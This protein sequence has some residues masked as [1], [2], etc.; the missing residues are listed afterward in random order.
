MFRFNNRKDASGNDGS[1]SDNQSSVNWSNFVHPH[2]FG[3]YVREIERHESRYDCTS[4][5]TVY[6]AEPIDGQPPIGVPFANLYGVGQCWLE[7]EMVSVL[8]GNAYLKCV[9]LV[10]VVNFDFGNFRAENVNPSGVNGDDDVLI[11]I[12]KFVQLPEGMILYRS[13]S[14]VRLQSVDFFRN[15]IGEKI[16]GLTI[17]SFQ[18]GR[19]KVP[20]DREVNVPRGISPSIGLGHLPSH[21]IETRSQT[22]QELPE[23]HAHGGVKG[24]TVKPLDV[25]SVQRVILANDGVRFFHVSGHVPIES[26]E[27][28]L[29]PFG[30]CYEIPCSTRNHFPSP[31]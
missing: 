1:V 16:E 3:R 15:V 20:E 7:I 14:P 18:V 29:C 24:F 8:F 23:F 28:K 21:L 2:R 22:V 5:E 6:V 11:K 30:L 26:I 4:Y 25:S 19:V 31:L 27:V 10:E 17:A 12:A 9:F 13:R